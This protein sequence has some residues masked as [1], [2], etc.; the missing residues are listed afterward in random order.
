MS[1]AKIKKPLILIALLAG[2][3]APRPLEPARLDGVFRA[4]LS[5]CYGSALSYLREHPGCAS[6]AVGVDKRL[7]ASFEGEV[8]LPR[9]LRLEKTLEA[10]DGWDNDLYRISL[11]GSNPILLKEAMKGL[12][13]MKEVSYFE[14]DYEGEAYVSS[15]DGQGNGDYWTEQ[16]SLADAW[17]IT[18]GSSTN[19]VGVIDTGI[20][21]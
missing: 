10:G 11:N 13:K 2:A 9:G 19:L 16:I 21:R 3:A 6:L 20:N 5:E 18:T 14:P 4:D 1:P 8:R 17:D 7:S 15:W 12:S